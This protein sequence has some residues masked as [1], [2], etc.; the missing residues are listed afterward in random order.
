MVVHISDLVQGCDTADDGLIVRDSLLHALHA[1]FYATVTFAGISTVTTS[2]V[3]AA[4]VDLL[5]HMSLDQIKRRVR[6]VD[7]TRQINDMIRQ[8]LM[9]A[10][11]HLPHAA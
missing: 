11:E 9:F 6:V 4:F 2:F 5:R 8:R 7:A 10:A 3:N 1:E